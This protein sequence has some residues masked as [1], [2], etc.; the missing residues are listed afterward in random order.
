MCL[1][2]LDL[3][4]RRYESFFFRLYA[5]KYFFVESCLNS[6]LMIFLLQH[7]NLFA[8]FMD[9]I[10]SRD[11]ACGDGGRR[12]NSSA[13]DG[14]SE[15]RG[16]LVTMSSCFVICKWNW[17]FISFL[18]ALLPS[19]EGLSSQWCSVFYHHRGTQQNDRL[20]LVGEAANF[21]KV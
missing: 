1:L 20:C 6:T 19:Y 17:L 18:S 9:D 2:E 15:P 21:R 4:V 13:T 10:S 14:V 5:I 3:F 8:S 12:P 11:G 7:I 16:T